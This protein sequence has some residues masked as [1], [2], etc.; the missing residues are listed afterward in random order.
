MLLNALAIARAETMFWEIEVFRLTMPAIL[1]DDEYL[2][3]LE[4]LCHRYDVLLAEVER[5]SVCRR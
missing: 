2:E 4:E 3:K 5:T 1:S